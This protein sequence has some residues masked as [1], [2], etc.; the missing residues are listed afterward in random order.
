MIK[1]Q[2][3]RALDADTAAAMASIVAGNAGPRTATQWIGKIGGAANPKTAQTNLLDFDAVTVELAEP[4]SF[5]YLVVNNGHAPQDKILA[6]LANAG[7]SLGLAG[8]SS[9]Q[10]DIAKGLVKIV[11]VKI[12]EAISG[13]LPAVGSIL[14]KI[15]TWLM[16]KLA[17]AA[18]ESCDGVVAVE[19]RAMMG[20][21][22][23][24]L[25]DNGRKT[26]NIT[27]QHSG[28]SSPAAC[29]DN[30]AYEVTWSI[31]PL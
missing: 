1:V 15:E 5:S 6:A 24:M 29:G 28:T 17:D 18:F 4:M 31:R 13:A 8:S 7:D 11:S 27:T 30:S 9:M 12:A 23:F 22:L 2:T 25:T 19:L 21:D 20:R 14:G 16:G 10:E 26:V 3:T